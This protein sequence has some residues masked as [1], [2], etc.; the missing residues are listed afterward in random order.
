MNDSI[1]ILLV[2]DEPR[3]CESLAQILILSGY[4]V[5]I[6][7]SGNE[8]VELLEKN[9]FD[10]LLLD[11]E[12]PDILGYQIMDSLKDENF[13]TATIMLTGHATVETAIEALK[14]GAYDYLK[15][16]IDHDLLFNTIDKAIKHSRLAKA[17]RISEERLKTLAEASW[18]GIVILSNGQLLDANRQF[19]DMFGYQTDELLG[20]QIL[21]KIL[22]A[23]S[24]TEV[25]LRIQNEAFGSHEAI[26]VKKD[27]TEFPI[28]TSCR[29]ME[30][31][32]R[33]VRVCAIRDIT[34]RVKAEQEKLELQKQLAI[35]NKMETLGLMAGS[36]AHDLNNILSGIVTLPE[37][38]LMQMGNDHKHSELIKIIQKAGKE[39]ASVVSD[40][41]TV[42]RG[43]TAEKCICNLSTLVEKYMVTIKEKPMDPLLEGVAIKLN[44][45][46]GLSNSYCSVVHINKVLMNLIGNA[47]EEMEGKGTIVVSTKNVFI[48][49][50]FLGYET[51]EVGDYVVL[52]VTDDGPGIIPEDVKKIFEPFYSKKIMGR[53]GTGLGLAI[54]WNT[55]HDHGGFIDVKSD[56]NGTTFDLYFPMTKD[57]VEE[58]RALP[59]IEKHRGY[60]EKILVIDD[61]KKQQEIASS[62]LDGLG[63]KTDVVG[64]GEEAIAYIK[65]KSV[66]LIVLDMI[67]DSGINGRETYEE[68][69]KIN[70]KQRAIIASGFAEN[71]EVKQTLF[72]GASQF[73]KKPYT[74]TQMGQAVKQAL[75]Q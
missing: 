39:A 14:K 44:C 73:V 34:E 62:L 36:V 18:E 7:Q 19:F 71:E 52:S 51:I 41:I 56:G 58:K 28:E 37:L 69:L 10:L 70:P 49:Q 20:Q 42:A 29:H 63:Y 3:F 15:K 74:L 26:G 25:S 66:D 68:I 16:P 21:D 48:E 13:G 1:R 64:S 45:D 17:L 9:A 65:L 61:Q 5:T 50:P 23:A 33:E 38:L 32:G 27:G 8:A 72:L 59:S 75:S 22:S 6:A 11:V 57:A 31:Q 24:L 43:A 2:D 47:A 67:M 30:Y 35:A 54:V 60:G 46:P 40:L 53:S 55:V 4:Q 12:L